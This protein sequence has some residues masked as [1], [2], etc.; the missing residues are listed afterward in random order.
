MAIKELT[1]QDLLGMDSMIKSFGSEL[2]KLKTTYEADPVK[3]ELIASLYNLKD[4]FS[5]RLF[6]YY[7]PVGP[8][9]KNVKDKL[10]KIFFTTEE[11]DDSALKIQEEHKDD[12]LTYLSSVM[13]INNKKYREAT[14]EEIASDKSVYTEHFK[15]F[16][17]FPK[18]SFAYRNEFDTAKKSRFIKSTRTLKDSEK[19][20]ISETISTLGANKD[21]PDEKISLINDEHLYILNGSFS[22]IYTT[23]A[24]DYLSI[25]SIDS[26]IDIRIS[27]KDLIPFIK[28]GKV[29]LGDAAIIVEASSDTKADPEPIA[30]VVEKTAKIEQA[31]PAA[32]A[33]PTP[34]ATPVAQAKP[35]PAPAPVAKP[36]P[37][38]SKAEAFLATVAVSTEVVDAV[39]ADEDEQAMLD[40]LPD[41]I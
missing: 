30:P 22:K 10:D 32:P 9:T 21:K 11:Q 3:K 31:K 28:S 23:L 39:D 6:S 12:I 19:K 1:K 29:K 2:W 13:S 35:T 33:K 26:A 14:P 16:V 15:T 7:M 18:S 24:E 20:V 40:D 25:Y 38:M 4:I 5:L 27:L 34:P 37:V 8:T 36:E 17:F 41:D